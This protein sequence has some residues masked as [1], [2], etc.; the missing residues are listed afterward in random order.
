MKL[1]IR[2]LRL[3]SMLWIKGRKCMQHAV[4]IGHHREVLSLDHQ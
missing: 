1:C 3:A 2:L 4:P